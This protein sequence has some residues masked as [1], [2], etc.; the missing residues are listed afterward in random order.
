VTAALYRKI[1]TLLLT[2]VLLLVL[3]VVLENILMDLIVPVGAGIRMEDQVG[4]QPASPLAKR[5][6]VDPD[7]G[8]LHV[9]IVFLGNIHQILG[10]LR[11]LIVHK[12][13]KLEPL[14]DR[15]HVTLVRLVNIA[16]TVSNVWPA[17]RGRKSQILIDLDVFNA[18]M[19]KN[20]ILHEH[21]VFLVAPQTL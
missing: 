13:M 12:A 16:P 8:H 3:I 19:V 5:S 21:L 20:L 14:R 17:P 18:Q 4:G 2:K 11:V 15:I 1:A 9:L 7:Y 6:W 10:V